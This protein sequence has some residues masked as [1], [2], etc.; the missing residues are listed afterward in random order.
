MLANDDNGNELNAEFSVVSDGE[1]LSLVM[2]SAG[3]KG[4]GPWPRNHQYIPALELLLRRL[5]DRRAVVVS[6][7]VAS[8]QTAHLPEAERSIVPVPIDLADESDL[9]EVR[10][11]ITRAQGRSA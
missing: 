3:G 4:A 1:R 10:R 6:G 2:E 5:Q 8:S 7:V 11:R 9:E